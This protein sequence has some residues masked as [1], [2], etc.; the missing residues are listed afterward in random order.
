MQETL[1]SHQ[2]LVDKEPLL[3]SE[4][5]KSPSFQKV[6]R[7]KSIRSV[8]KSP[9]AETNELLVAKEKEQTS[10]PARP[11]KAIKRTERGAASSGTENAI[12]GTAQR[13]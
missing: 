13:L 8:I 12:K 6:A 3:S 10:A 4:V 2:K 7:L 9:E 5:E 11:Q 1:D